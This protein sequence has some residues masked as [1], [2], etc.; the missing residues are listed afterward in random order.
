[1]EAERWVLTAKG[2][3]EEFQDPWSG[4][5]NYSLKQTKQT[6]INNLIPANQTAFSGTA[7]ATCFA[8]SPW[9]SMTPCKSCVSA[10]FK[11]F[12]PCTPS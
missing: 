5:M 6:K 7:L 10:A 11:H 2:K 1:M 3:Q 9:V 8:T 12:D 4:W